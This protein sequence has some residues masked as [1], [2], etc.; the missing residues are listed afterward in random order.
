MPIAEGEVLFCATCRSAS[1][2]RPPFTEHGLPARPQ[3]EQNNPGPEPIKPAGAALKVN[4]SSNP[5]EIE[6]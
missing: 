4:E 3:A 1:G 5:E 2:N 6:G